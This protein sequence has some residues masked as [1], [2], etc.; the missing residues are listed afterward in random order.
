[1]SNV[2]ALNI[3]VSVGLG[4]LSI[5]VSGFAVWLSFQFNDRSKQALDTVQELTREIKTSVEVGLS[6]QQDMSDKM[7][8]SILEDEYGTEKESIDSEG[9]EVI[10]KMSSK[11]EEIEERLVQR[12]TG[13]DDNMS[14]DTDEDIMS[15]EDVRKIL[16]NINE[17]IEEGVK[18]EQEAKKN[19]REYVKEW[20]EYPAQLL[21]TAAVLETEAESFSDLQ[22]VA[23]EYNLPGEW[24]RGVSNLL[25]SKIMGGTFERF[26]F[27]DE[28]KKEL[29]KWV[30]KNEELISTVKEL[31]GSLSAEEARELS[32][33][34][35]NEKVTIP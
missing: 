35:V 7:L 34:L 16:E 14:D 32:R 21:V 11:I 13:D 9:E 22:E 28:I 20:K 33:G 1:M 29:N 6:Q 31:Y 19:V 3:G 18:I 24:R 26:R 12:L 25:N 27:D 8:D 10:E 30:L 17:E 5:G 23:D 4:L 15:V 2:D